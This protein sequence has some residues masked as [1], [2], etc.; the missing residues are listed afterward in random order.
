MGLKIGKLL[1]SRWSIQ[2]IIGVVAGVFFGAMVA[3]A[4]TEDV[5]YTYDEARAG[6][7]NTGHLT[8]VSNAAATILYDYNSQGK[9][10]R[11]RY[12]VDGKT[13]TRTYRYDQGNRLRS[14]T[15]SDGEVWP[16]A[17]EQY[18]YDQA[19]RLISI[20]GAIDEVHYNGFSEVGSV[21]YANGTRVEN[22]YNLQRNW[23]L[24]T[25]LT[26]GAQVLFEEQ[27]TRDTLG[28]ITRI[29]SNRANGNWD[30]TYDVINQLTAATNVGNSSLSRSFTY[31]PSGNLLSKSDVGTY[32]YPAPTAP[33]PHAPVKAGPWT[34][35]YD[36]NGNMLTG[37][38]RT[39]TY[40]GKDRPVS[41]TT[42][43][44]TTQ[45]V[46]GPDGARLKKISGGQTTLYLGGD[47]EILPDGKVVKHLDDAVRRVGS[48]TNWIHRDHMSSVRML[49]NSSGNI[50]AVSRYQPYGKRTD[51]Q[52][53]ADTPRES[54]GWI[55]ERDDPETGLTY[56]NARYYD[57]ELARFIQAD[58]LNPTDP[59]VGT[60]RYAYA[61]NN[62]VLYSD[63]SGH[64]ID[65]FNE[66]GNSGSISGARNRDEYRDFQRSRN[67]YSDRSNSRSYDYDDYRSNG[68]NYDR[69]SRSRRTSREDNWRRDSVTD[70]RIYRAE[71][72]I[73]KARVDGTYGAIVD[74]IPG[75]GDAKAFYQAKSAWDYGLAIVGLVPGIGDLA[76]K[77]VKVG[78]KIPNCDLCGPPSKR[79]NAP[80]GNDGHPVELHHRNQNPQGPL[81]EM[82]RTEHRLGG[83]F[84]AN[85]VNV[86]QL[87]SQI[88]RKVWRK[89]QRDYWK[90]EW[91]KG[92]FD[93][94]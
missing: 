4:G 73:Y 63:P 27:Y 10:V 34:F 55:G 59:Y 40:D 31:S 30:Y 37:K 52:Q 23:L 94:M 48:S 15:F 9:L 13:Y 91:D 78:R 21:N 25:K 57:P 54:K 29:R 61:A 75:A 53:A 83:S 17:S 3:Q 6:Y 70:R 69:V 24:G 86:G 77:T 47:E 26:K 41:V 62:P 20:P 39:I 1:S 8:S 42:G 32:L 36:G 7:H 12:I 16:P 84:K 19:G 74:F 2:S 38:G 60:N 89:Q 72:R 93:G 71:N 65:D 44:V 49:T 18:Q 79:G 45:Y 28:R 90:T 43:G 92:R 50:A 76:A 87:P 5:T 51:V 58:W 14:R 33:R 11:E 82:T 68:G 85:H 88:D 81:D 64:R 67:A 35:T 56:L 80:I 46:Y 22:S 66:I